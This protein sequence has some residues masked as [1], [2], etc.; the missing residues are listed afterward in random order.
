MIDQA[1]G[2]ISGTPANAGTTNFTVRVTDSLGGMD[3]QDLSIT[4]L[5]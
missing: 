1:T 2:K 3:T 4:I 5:P